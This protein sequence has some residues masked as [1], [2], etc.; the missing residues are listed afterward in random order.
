L[1]LDSELW[2]FLH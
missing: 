2:T 1:V